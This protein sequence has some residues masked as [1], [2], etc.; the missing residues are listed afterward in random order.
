[1]PDSQINKRMK[2]G[3][4]NIWISGVCFGAGIT[5]ILLWIYE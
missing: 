3:M 5:C 1:M 4:F 2:I